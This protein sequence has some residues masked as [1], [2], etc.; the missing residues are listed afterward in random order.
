M[1]RHTVDYKGYTNDKTHGSNYSPSETEGYK[2]NLSKEHENEEDEE[3]K[4]NT[5]EINDTHESK[6]SKNKLK[7]IS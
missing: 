2:K 4:E 6:L 1:F 5:S 7:N 3:F